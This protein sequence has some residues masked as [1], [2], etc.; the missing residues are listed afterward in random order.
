[1]NF[2]RQEQKF[3]FKSKTVTFHELSQ[4]EAFYVCYKS[5]HLSPSS[6]ILKEYGNLLEQHACMHNNKNLRLIKV[7]FQLTKPKRDFL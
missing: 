7:S 2:A 6:L 5:F 1:M 3:I 4:Q